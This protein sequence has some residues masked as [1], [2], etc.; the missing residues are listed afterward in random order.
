MRAD[1][2]CLFSLP[3]SIISQ[4]NQNQQN[5]TSAGEDGQIW[6]FKHPSFRR[7]Q[8]HLLT[9]IKRKSSRPGKGQQIGSPTHNSVAEDNESRPDLDQSIGTVSPSPQ[10]SSQ[11]VVPG[12]MSSNFAFPPRRPES[13][14]FNDPRGMPYQRPASHNGDHSR[15]PSTAA[16]VEGFGLP[17]PQ[18]SMGRPRAGTDAHSNPY[19]PPSPSTSLNHSIQGPRQHHHQE[20]VDSSHHKSASSS[21]VRVDDLSDRID[22][23]I[24]HASYL[25]TQLRNVSEQLFHSQQT[26]NATRA[27]SLRMLNRLTNVCSSWCSTDTREGAENRRIML[28]ACHEEMAALHS[29][30]EIEPG[31]LSPPITPAALPGLHLPRSNYSGTPLGVAGRD[32]RGD[33]EREREREMIRMS[34]RMR[35]EGNYSSSTS[36]Y[37][38]ASSSASRYPPPPPTLT[39][40]SSNSRISPSFPFSQSQSQS[41]PR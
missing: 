26:E 40:T 34:P 8:I 9:D 13:N 33:R 20:T 36:P 27:H 32:S 17:V 11:A 30:L 41:Q 31:V 37:S 4:V 38:Y 21:N 12:T 3:L 29:L 2:T 39:R 18:V 6:E 25:E 15:F 14:H 19:N 7:G 5:A 23:V 35:H 28:E 24:R 22:A 10:F 1:L 16:S